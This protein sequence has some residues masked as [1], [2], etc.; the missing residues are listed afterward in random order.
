MQGNRGICAKANSGLQPRLLKVYRTVHM[1]YSTRQ[2]FI[3]LGNV[4]AI[5]LI[6]SAFSDGTY[7]IYFDVHIFSPVALRNVRSNSSLFVVF[8]GQKA[9]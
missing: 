4:S 1:E 5:V 2:G 7:V 8:Q 6:I 3:S 9:R